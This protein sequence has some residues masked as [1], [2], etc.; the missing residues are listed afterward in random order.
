MIIFGNVVG[1]LSP[2]ADWDQEDPTKA[3]FILGK[4]SVYEELESVLHDAK[5]YADGLHFTRQVS[6]PASGWSSSAPYTQTVPV[7]GMTQN[8]TPHYSVVYSASN[9]LPEKE[10]FAMV[11]DLDSANGSVTF[12]CFESKP[13]IDLTIQLEVNR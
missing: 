12:T 4:T 13:E 8:D 3:D 1:N 2:R 5:A 7:N 11:D 9:A 6:V 10:A